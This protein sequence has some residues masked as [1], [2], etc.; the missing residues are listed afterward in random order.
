MGPAT[1]WRLGSPRRRRPHHRA[2][3]G[4]APRDPAV[5]RRHVRRRRQRA[6]PAGLRVHRQR[7]LRRPRTA[8]T[9]PGDGAG[10]GRA[11]RRPRRDRAPGDPALLTGGVHTPNHRWEIAAALARVHR[12]HPAAALL[13]RI[14]AWL[15]E[16]PDIDADGLWSERSPNY[17]S[18]V[19]GPSFLVLAAV[20]D[21][22]A[23]L[24]P[25]RR[26]LDATLA[27]LLPD[28][29]VE[30]VQSRRQDQSQPFGIGP[31][32]PLLWHVAV[33]DGRGD[34]AAVAARAAVA[35]TWQ[36]AA[37]AARS[38]TDPLL[39]RPLPEPVALAPAVHTF[40]DARLVHVRE[41][42][43]SVVLFAGSDVP[44]QGHV[45]S[46]LAEQPDVPAGRRRVGRAV[47]R[48]ALAGVLRPRTVPTD[49]ARVPGRRTV[50]ADRDRVRRLPP[51]V[52]R[53]C[54]P[55]GRPLPARRRRPVLRRHGVRHPVRRHGGPQHHRRRRGDPG[56]R[57]PRR[58]DRGG[59][60]AVVPAADVPHRGTLTGVETDAVTGGAGSW[61][62][63]Q[64][65]TASVPTS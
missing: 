18:A 62:R 39:G 24:D 57:R 1:A 7:R 42:D 58:R 53:E 29:T 4:P 63:G 61:R 48:A 41:P 46:G 2:R 5:A 35:E 21:R 17:A 51:A 13:D 32:A 25:V 6:L 12:L 27:L 65:A 54:S 20:L 3:L 33:L 50:P 45:R 30:T 22:P 47:R 15:A 8:R 52:A 34:L 19:S 40:A 43:R 10:S 26:S 44:A 37:V 31:F 60:S 59:R 38:M 11:G 14:D 28:D 23:L 49:R 16:G 55:A 9:A 56:R 36:P 64:A